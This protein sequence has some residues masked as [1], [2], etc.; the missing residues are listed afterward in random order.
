MNVVDTFLD[1]AAEHLE[2]LESGLMALTTRVDAATVGEVFRAAHSLKGGAASCGFDAL[3]KFTH[4]LENVLDAIRKDHLD[5]TPPV[6]DV[7]LRSVDVL[8]QF[9]QACTTG[10]GSVPQLAGALENE[11]AAT[12]TPSDA[13]PRPAAR[14]GAQ[15]WTIAFRPSPDMLLACIDPSLI[16][17]HLHELGTLTIDCDTSAVPDLDQL[18]SFQLY[19]AWSMTL[20]TDAP[21]EQIRDILEWCNGEATWSLE[22]VPTQRDA[23][24]SS[25]DPQQTAPRRQSIRVDPAKIDVLLN[26]VGELVITQS[27]LRDVTD[28][29][30][31][32]TGRELVECIPQLESEVRSLQDAVL[33]MR[34]VP[35][36]SAFERLPRVVFDAARA[37]DKAVDIQLA[38][39]WT[40]V[41]REVVQLLTDPLVHMV[42]NAVD[43]GLE[44]PDDRVRAGKPRTGTVWVTA[45]HQRGDIVVTIRDDGRGIDRARLRAK[46]EKIG[47]V[48]P[49]DDIEITEQIIFHPGFSTASKISDLSGR[50]V[51]LDVVQQNV[52]SLGGTL[53]VHSEVGIGT[54]F[55][56]RLPMTLAIL[57]GQLTRVGDEVFV[58]P[59]RSIVECLVPSPEA[60]HRMPG[61]GTVYQLRGTQIPI[62]SVC[63]AFGVPNGETN[64]E[65][66]PLIVIDDGGQLVALAVDS[67]G[68]QQQVVLKSLEQNYRSVH[69][70]AG[71]TVLGNGRIAMVVDPG[72]MGRGAQAGAAL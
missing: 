34:M 24:G 37:L 3:A 41:D 40:E 55:E 27:R 46:A 58:V 42:R 72:E 65:R 36:K 12:L 48:Q 52:Q 16:L 60:L 59:V 50:G 49:G 9:L 39:E 29:L 68:R 22:P 66:C 61:V 35:V 20:L 30:P 64:L 17:H 33:A 67:L 44:M 56:V 43:H 70:I 15:A 25:G 45:A 28:R 26:L 7:L 5:I 62:V 8:R 4:R 54:T 18:E 2:T 31:A 51:G 19:L 53:A 11:L 13:A 1:E 71:A 47:L 38:G 6:T 21:E 63:E 23:P 32:G 69:G 14:S 57:D 10:D